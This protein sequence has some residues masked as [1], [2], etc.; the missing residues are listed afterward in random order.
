MLLQSLL[1]AIVDLAEDRQ[2]RVREAIIE[3]IPLLAQQ[4]GRDFFDAQL[5][6]LCTAWLGDC[7][8]SIRE[9]ATVNI[10]RLVET[11]GVEWAR[12]AIVP[13]VLAMYE[14]PN[15]LYRMTTL[16]AVNLLVEVLDESTIMDLVL[17]V[18]LT[19]AGD[20]VP[21]VRFNVAKT[22]QV[23]AQRCPKNIV[24]ERI[25]PVLTQLRDDPDNDVQFF[26]QRALQA[27]A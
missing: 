9:A 6:S 19:M 11:F 4:L 16:F 10:R 15:Y 17:P 20:N 26:A 23:L 27:S 7:V 3:Y 12:H 5:S 18:V 2:W 24:E 1:P 21:N 22:L 25:K 13:K 8:Y 14:H